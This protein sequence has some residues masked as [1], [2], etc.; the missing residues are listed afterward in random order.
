MAIF[1]ILAD[2]ND[3]TNKITPLFESLVITDNTGTQPDNITLTLADDG[4]F[5]YPTKDTKL[6][7]WT[8]YNAEAMS[9]KGKFVVEKID[10]TFPEQKII[11]H[12]TSAKLRSSFKTQRDHTWQETNI[13]EMVE[14]MAQRNGFKPVIANDFTTINV[15][16][17]D[18]SGQSDADLM[19]YLA[20]LYGATV[21]V[22]NDRI[23]F[24][25]RGAGQNARGEPIPP[26]ELNI[27][28]ITSGKLTLD[29]RHAVDAVKAGYYDTDQAKQI[30]VYAGNENGKRITKLPQS[31]ANQQLAQAAAAAE[32]DHRQRKEFVLQISKMPAIPELVAERVINIT[33]GHRDQI[34]RPWI[35]KTL[36]E[37]M[38]KNGFTQKITAV[39]PRIDYNSIPR[40]A[41]T[42]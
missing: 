39:T 41:N 12:G 8:G 2:S 19:N 14:Q 21:K 29:S 3:V 24:L 40:L 22:T 4:K 25:V 35:I 9:I 36:I 15:P 1:K 27:N 42:Q 16:Y 38:D 11:I 32:F 10:L 28:Q 33:G 6:E 30:Y 23:V 18:Q 34:N 17:Y 7:V 5:V 13:F 31:F 20:D 37:T 26:I